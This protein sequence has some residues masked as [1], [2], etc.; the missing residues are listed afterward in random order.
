M[1]LALLKSQDGS[2]YFATADNTPVVSLYMN[3]DHSQD[4]TLTLGV[5]TLL[6]RIILTPGDE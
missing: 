4:E 3:E 6:A 2:T 5:L 1:I